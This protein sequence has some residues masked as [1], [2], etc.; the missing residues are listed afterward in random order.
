MARKAG[1]LAG[2]ELGP[3]LHRA[4]V[5]EA[6][7]A[8]KKERSQQRRKR[9]AEDGATGGDED[10]WREALPRLDE[11]LDELPERD[12]RVVLL[13]FFEGKDFGEIAAATGKTAAAVQKQSRRALEKMAG[14]LMAKGVKLS[15]GVLAAGMTVE[16]GKAAPAGWIAGIGMSATGGASGVGLTTFMTTKTKVWIPAAV[17]LAAIPLGMQ[18]VKIRAA[19]REIA[20]RRMAAG[21]NMEVVGRAEPPRE[22]ASTSRRLNLRS[23]AE[24]LYELEKRPDLMRRNE[25]LESIARLDRH[26]LESSIREVS[27]LEIGQGRKE[28]LLRYLFDGLMQLDPKRALDLAMALGEEEAYRVQLRAG[29]GG[30]GIDLPFRVWA[31][32]A[33]EEARE[34]LRAREADGSLA[35]FDTAENRLIDGMRSW[36]VLR[37]LIESGEAAAKEYL[38]EFPEN[39]RAGLLVRAV[40]TGILRDEGQEDGIALAFGLLAPEERAPVFRTLLDQ[41]LAFASPPLDGLAAVHGIPGL[42]DGEKAGLRERGAERLMNRNWLA[43]N[44]LPTREDVAAL[45]SWLSEVDPDGAERTLGKALGKNRSPGVVDLLAAY[46]DGSPSDRV[47]AAFLAA[48]GLPPGEREVAGLW[49][50]I[51]DRDLREQVEEEIAEGGNE[52]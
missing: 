3:W 33:P 39:E 10:G 13:R 28:L 38:L 23:V 1:Q 5:Y 46:L 21:P 51:S 44:P 6:G 42:E 20:D 30:L 50:R 11:V 2:R 29:T 7:K 43:G 14:M 22:A 27:G 31:A 24:T 35:E 49:A 8:L 48:R 32:H 17:L 25:T 47:I 18:Q 37:T 36:S 45:R 16:L 12:R 15:V 19:E 41:K 40:T 34:W 52:P 9:L 26:A 4:A